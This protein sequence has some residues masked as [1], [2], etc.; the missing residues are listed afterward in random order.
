MKKFNKRNGRSRSGV[1]D[2][3]G[4]LLIL[5]ITVTLFS[6]IMFYVANMPE[7]AQATFT[8]LEPSPSNVL[9]DS[10]IWV[11][12]THKGGQ[13]LKGWSTG[14][15]IFVNGTLIPELSVS[16]GGV[17]EDWKTGEVW[18]YK[19]NFTNELTG[20]SIMIVAKDTNSIVWQTDLLGGVTNIQLAPII[21]TR[22][23]SPS[24]G[25]E[26]R[27]LVLFVQ[28]MDPNDDNITAVTADMTTLG[29]G[30][31]TIRSSV[32]EPVLRGDIQSSEVL[33]GQ[34]KDHHHRR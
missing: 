25:L 22:F 23:T 19:V 1:S 9:D 4:N 32:K 21:G 10:T 15:Y 28:V 7:P 13:T 24:P 14:I 29:L 20:L 12:V 3:I 11:N 5:A 30:I 17:G 18:R 2:I 16:D 27:S 8:D 34:Q 6:S 26:N 31:K 33:L